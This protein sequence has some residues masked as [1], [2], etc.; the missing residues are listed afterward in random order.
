MLLTFS[1]AGSLV[2]MEQEDTHL[3]E[4]QKLFLLHCN[5]LRGFILGLLPDRA[6]AEDVL[7][8]VFLIVTAK[9]AKFQ[10]GADFLA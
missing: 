6:A 9:A 10:A 3:R 2:C 1:R 7:Q 4:V 5:R 8:E